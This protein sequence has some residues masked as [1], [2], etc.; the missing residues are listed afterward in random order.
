MRL[1]STIFKALISPTIS[2]GARCKLKC[3][4]SGGKE[5]ELVAT[6]SSVSTGASVCVLSMVDVVVDA[7]GSDAGS[8]ILSGVRSAWEVPSNVL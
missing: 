7:C 6:D 8:N 2:Y 4:V 3:S 5:V 1:P